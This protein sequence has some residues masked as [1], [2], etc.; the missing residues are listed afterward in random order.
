MPLYD[1]QCR[2][3]GHEFEALVRPGHDAD[4]PSCH[5]TDLERLLSGFAVASEDRT[6]A[7]IKSARK[8]AIAG[9]REEI[10]AEEAYRR[11]HEH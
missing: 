2:T 7:A 6:R 5:G 8:R 3:C 4:C 11:E 9:R 1:F 10:A